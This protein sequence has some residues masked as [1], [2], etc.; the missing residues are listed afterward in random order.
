MYSCTSLRVLVSKQRCHCVTRCSDNPASGNAS[1][2]HVIAVGKR[3]GIARGRKDRVLCPQLAPAR[4]VGLGRPLLRGVSGS[5]CSIQHIV[6]P[7]GRRQV[8][9]CY[10]HRGVQRQRPLVAPHRLLRL[11]FNF[12]EVPAQMQARATA[13]AG[14]LAA[15]VLHSTAA[16]QPA[17]HA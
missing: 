16:T 15:R 9:T 12:L 3:L 14:E 13:S 17:L 6:Q 8:A 10:C 2:N 1:S 11:V 5:S 7:A 4:S